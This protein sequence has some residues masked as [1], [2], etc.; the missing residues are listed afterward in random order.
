[1]PPTRVLAAELGISRGVAVGAYA[2]LSAAGLV[3][4]RVGAET[5]VAVSANTR[6]PHR[7]D[8][9]GRSASRWRFDLDPEVPDVVA[10]PLREWQASMQKATIDIPTHGLDYRS[11][12]GLPELREALG[13][14]LARA[15]G[16][17]VDPADIVL[18]GSVRQAAAVARHVLRDAGVTRLAT[19]RVGHPVNRRVFT[20]NDP[21]VTWLEVDHEGA[22]LRG[23]VLT[24][25]HAVLI[26][27]VHQFPL[28]TALS[29]DRADALVESSATIIEDD[30]NSMLRHD[31]AATPAL[32]SRAPGRTIYIGSLSRIAAPGLR[33][34]YLVAPPAI[35]RAAARVV[36][37]WGMSPSTLEQIALTDFIGRGCLDAHVRRQRVRYGRRAAELTALLEAELPDL[38]PEVPSSAF[39]LILP[40][41]AGTTEARVRNLAA[42]R[43]IR[44]R[45]MASHVL[46]GPPF[47]SALVLGYATVGR[48]QLSD[49]VTELRELFER[50]VDH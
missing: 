14:Y 29:A 23:D 4:S 1:M 50:A 13:S 34:G 42:Q 39:H 32:Q 40:L 12:T 27:P 47:P 21:P 6:T 30:S 9:S 36:A 46:F 8:V 49:V 11:S 22:I 35:A 15:R 43:Q 24:S 3:E 20:E 17:R 41:R 48:H 28:G 45:G 7:T 2:Q 25:D 33:L 10:F 16:M 5:V 18:C 37:L 44:L 38:V 19:P 31:G 26:N